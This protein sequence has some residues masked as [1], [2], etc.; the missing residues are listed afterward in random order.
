M[1]IIGKKENGQ[2]VLHTS[3]PVDGRRQHVIVQNEADAL[4]LAYFWNRLYIYDKLRAWLKQR[5]YALKFSNDHHRIEQCAQLLYM[6]ECYREASLNQL[7]L[8]IYNQRDLFAFVAPGKKSNHYKI[9]INTV[10]PI[11][12]F[13]EGIKGGNILRVLK[14]EE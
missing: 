1:T 9:Y 13:C 4:R 7:C 11:I 3:E 2:M 8:L 5:V 10:L 6:L 12:T 14:S